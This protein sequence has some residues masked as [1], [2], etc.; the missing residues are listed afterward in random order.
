MMITPPIRAIQSL[1]YSRKLPM[2]VAPA[3]SSTKISV[4]PLTKSAAC[5]ITRRRSNP[6]CRS[7]SDIPVTKDR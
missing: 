5:T 7:S 6:S 2:K 3:P 1:L 4:K